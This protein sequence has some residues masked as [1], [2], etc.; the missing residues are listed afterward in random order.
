MVFGRVKKILRK[1]ITILMASAM[2]VTSV[3]QA[4]I[5]AAAAETQELQT[6]ETASET[7]KEETGTPEEVSGDGTEQITET[8]ESGAVQGGTEEG[9][10]EADKKEETTE[11]AG[12]EDESEGGS[13]E[14]TTEEVSEGET[15]ENT[16]AEEETPEP[17]L[18]GEEGTAAANMALRFEVKAA[19]GEWVDSIQTDITGFSEVT[20]LNRDYTVSY[21]L[22]IPKT[23]DFTGNYYVKPVTKLNGT[24]DGEAAS[25][26]WTD[27]EGGVNVGKSD[28]QE[29]AENPDLLKYTFSGKLGE[30]SE[31]Y[32]GIDAVVVAAGTSDCTYDGV[33]FVD[34]VKVSDADG[35][36]LAAQDFTGYSGAVELGN[37]DG[38][39]GGEGDDG[40][41]Q[42]Q[43]KVIYEQNFDAIT[44]LT[45]LGSGD[46]GTNSD[47]TKPEL[48]EIASGNKALKYTTDLSNSEGWTTVFQPEFQLA[49]GYTEKITD[50]ANMSFDVYIPAEKAD[51]NIKTMKAQAV[52]KCGAD[53]AWTTQQTWLSYTET[54]FQD[55]EEAPGYKKVH[56]SIDLDDFKDT[57]GNNKTIADIIP[58]YAVI[59]CFAGDT[60]AYEGDIYLDNLVVTAYNK[61]SEEPPVIVDEDVTLS[62]E[63]S[64][65][66]ADLEE[67]DWLYSGSK[68]V[69]NITAGE[70]TMLSLSVDYTGNAGEGWSEAKF[71]YTHPEEVSSMNG[72]NTL[73]ADLYYKPSNK[74]KGN[75]AVKVFCGSL[76]IDKNVTVAEGTPVEGIP[77]LEGYYKTE[78]EI[79]FKTKDAA[80]RTLTLG[81]VGQNTDYKGD[82]LLDHMRFTQVIA[83][84]IYVDSTVKVKKGD[85]IVVSE[86]GRSLT[87]AS[88]NTVAIPT[89]VSLVDAEAIEATKNLY[90]YLEA[91]GKSDSVI[92]GHQNDTH[93]KAGSKEDGFSNSDTKD[94]TGSIAGVVG[95]D[96]LSLTGNEASDWDT[97]YE[98][99]INKVVQ[100]TKEAA[101]E[102][103]IVTLS[104]HMPNFALIDEKVKKF[105]E[106]GKT[107]DKQETLGYWETDGKKIY[108]FSGYTPGELSGN[109]VERIMPGQDL[110]YLYT[111]YLDMVADYAKAVEGDGIT[112]LFRPLHE[113]TGSWFWWGAA[114]CD[115]TAYINL[116]RYTVD[117]L[118]ETKDVHN[119]L[120]VYGPGSEAESAA[121]YAVRYPGDAYVDMIGYDLYHSTPTQENEAA[122]LANVKK[123][124][125]ILRE[126]AA[127][128]HKLYAI[129]ET[130]VANGK[131]ALLPSG[132]EVQDWYMKLLEAVSE[133]KTAGGVN[134]GVCY[135]LVWANFSESDGFYLPFVLEKK[136]DGVLY[137]HETLD[138]FINFYNDGRSVF[139]TDMNNGF[140]KI[141]GVTN[142]TK[143]DRAA[144]YII[145][146][147]AGERILAETTIQARIT[148]VSETA[149]VRFELTSENDADLKVTLKAA[150]N[151]ATS[152]WE[153]ALGKEDLEKLG[154]ALGSITLL[155]NEVETAKTNVLFNMPEKESNPLVPDDFEDYGGSNKLLRSAWAGNKET[156]SSIGL[157]LTKEKD[158]V[159]G[160]SYGLEMDITLAASTAWAGA[161]KNM[162]QAD[163]SSVNALEFY[164]IPEKNGQKVVVQVTSGG[165]VFEVYMQEYPAY[166]E[167]AKK[168]MPVKV[169]VP[170]SCFVGR[171]DPKAV[172]KANAIDSIGLWCN[173][174]AVE[175][176]EFPL[177][178]VLYYDEIKAVTTDQ[179]QVSV[180]E[181][182]GPENPDNPDNPDK[183]D[184]PDNPDDPGKREGIWIEE[185]EAQT[186]TGKAVKPEVIVYDSGKQ[187]VKNKDYTVSYRDNTNAG[188]AKVIVKGKGN[189][190]EQLEKAFTILPKN[191]GEVTVSVP[192]AVA[193]KNSEQTIKVTVKDGK[194]TL[195]LNKDYELR[196]RAETIGNDTDEGNGAEGTKVDK[197]RAKEEGVYTVKIVA[198]SSGNYTGETSVSF[199]ITT[200]TLLTKAKVILPSNSLEYADGKEVVFD[201]EQIKVKVGSKEIARV[202]EDGKINYEISYENNV[203]VGKE[204]Y[205]VIR[206]GADS[207]YAG[208]VKKKFAVTGEAFNAK[209]VMIE[210]FRTKAD[211][212]GQKI[213]QDSMVL[214]NKAKFEAA[215]TDAEKQAAKLTE[216]VDYELSYKNNEKAGKATLTITGMGRYAGKIT[217]AYTITKVTLTADMVENKAVTVKHSKDGAKPDVKITYNGMV[218]VNGKDYTLS[219]T[220][221]KNI[222]TADKKAYI[223]VNGKGNYAGKLDKIVEMTIEPK[224]LRSGDITVVVPDM[225]YKAGI[226]EYKPVPVVYDNGKKL[227]KGTDYQV[228]YVKNTKEDVGVIGGEGNPAEYEATVI[229]TAVE[230]KN[231][232]VEEGADETEKAENNT[233]RAAFRITA[234]MIKDA[235]VEVINKQ[236]FQIQGVVPKKTDL[237]VTFG[238]D[239]EIVTNE[240][241][242][243]VSCTKNEK[244]GT[245]V[246]VI[247]GKGQYGGTKTVKF[248]IGARGM[249]TFKEKMKE[250]A[251]SMTKAL[252]F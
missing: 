105:E 136:E 196:F 3:P 145:A 156:S 162:D 142:T 117:Y 103:A 221:N 242:D 222:T 40:P 220:N 119:L 211:Y 53:W 101:A 27:G 25:W 79:S 159:F 133:D 146:P 137:G 184:K 127:E 57:E 4:S 58:L 147:K 81:I 139:A 129:T 181:Y 215:G 50:K 143:P 205:V 55:A 14:Q 190:G 252:G 151:Q 166:V 54:D 13:E 126:F 19:A 114:F 82:I 118:K 241:Y 38:V 155:V 11:D 236:S 34:N 83:E 64:A 161:T 66:S 150:Y 174:V 140:T 239:K 228:T 39:G 219:Y 214:Y 177:H 180:E 35:K 71:G 198:G 61:S 106:N 128:H 8:Q 237:K 167:A 37:M 12:Q 210:S 169:T 23:A 60:S 63:A 98:E 233:R 59:P 238:K 29:D 125:S 203:N 15:V 246:M 31:A 85:G 99:R 178:T 21:D 176:V 230:G 49:G 94:V 52:V 32:Q 225:K 182:T 46:L 111:A 77:D 28:F 235:K 80:F 110:N 164:T 2:I 248:A 165:E 195:K 62:L 92:F 33:I 1:S 24:V 207:E 65:W 244:K 86:D 75:F 193:Y 109:V 44:D 218:L 229:I 72:Y 10:N 243:I 68:A 97:P 87:T 168:D 45:E 189:Y 42:E 144:G 202:S 201:P 141:Q 123:Q 16:E 51:S 251:E 120:Y 26:Q 88:K 157:N 108:N 116:Y 206:A 138:D 200:K 121:D 149:D 20:N 240:E 131:I 227:K 217:K 73:K 234:K 204:A 30:A 9:G 78:V 216:G 152:Y 96:T 172:F 95:I 112:I 41:G 70:Q 104:A 124:N 183:P 7:E 93:H 154:A 89:E 153:A 187:L 197:I 249:E 6:A 90:A 17:A 48:A 188:E 158:K 194:R 213:L 43:T 186:Y 179:T 56:V 135:L 36:E 115:E 160:G 250:A 47:N 185:I 199:M 232:Y 132:N 163:W 209:T 22:Y 245:A 18:D 226:Q 173:A 67:E 171:D 134:G 113:N 76:G 5:S 69:G 175:G 224:S 148:G 102:G 74:T 122:Y 223:T 130:G 100:I 170:F 91:V 247:Q 107:G 192:E 212:N 231:Y 208:S 191:L 84:D